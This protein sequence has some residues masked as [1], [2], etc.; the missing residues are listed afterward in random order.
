MSASATKYNI[1]PP[2]DLRKIIDRTASYVIRK[3]PEFEQRVMDKERSNPKF[4]FLLTHDPYRPYY[5]RVKEE[6]RTGVRS[7]DHESTDSLP[8]QEQFA[9]KETLVKIQPSIFAPHEEVQV[10]PEDLDVIKTVAGFVAIHGGQFIQALMQRESPANPQFAFLKPTHSL[11]STYQRLISQYKM[12]L[13]LT[14]RNPTKRAASAN[15]KYELSL[16]DPSKLLSRVSQRAEYERKAKRR[17]ERREKEKEIIASVDWSVFSV[18]ETI[19]F[20]ETDKTDPEIDV[21]FDS[22]AFERL[23]LTEKQRFWEKA[24][25]HISLS[26]HSSAPQMHVPAAPLPA[27]SHTQIQPAAHPQPFAMPYYPQTSAVQ[28]G[29]VNVRTDYV[30]RAVA[31]Q[32]GTTVSS[33]QMLQ[34]AVCNQFIPAASMDEH[35]RVELLDPKWSEQR[36]RYQEKMHGSSSSILLSGA[37]VA[38]NLQGLLSGGSSNST[39]AAPAVMW[40][41]RKETAA[42]AQRKAHAQSVAQMN[43]RINSHE[44]KK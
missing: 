28:G 30:P 11:H 3:G 37:D 29:P 19:D 36:K 34:C 1:L 13:E 7:L 12:I 15:A 38:K 40:D 14:H 17:E 26:Q 10:A 31:I 35:I 43:A 20:D 6:L 33:P 21:P 27:M 41:G 18:V 4:A 8:D 23:S 16:I 2:P 42:E 32:Q 22:A 25:F 24:G 5:D 39:S 9:P 44:P